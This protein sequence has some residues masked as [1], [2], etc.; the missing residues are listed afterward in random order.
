VYLNKRKEKR[1]GVK[2][3]RLKAVS[4][5]NSAPVVER[6]DDPAYEAREMAR[7]SEALVPCSNTN[8]VSAF[9]RSWPLTLIGLL[10]SLVQV[11]KLTPKGETI[12]MTLLM[13]LS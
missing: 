3:A 10:F 6:A 13:A 7:R 12:H 2:P 11:L 9:I 4:V 1:A 5:L 8:V